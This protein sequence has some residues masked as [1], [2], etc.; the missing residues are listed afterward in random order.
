M[1]PGVV[2]LS[3]AGVISS[4]RVFARVVIVRAL[5]FVLR[6]MYYFCNIAK[7][8]LPTVQARQRKSFCFFSIFVLL[9]VLR[10]FL[11][12]SSIG[13]AIGPRALLGV[14]YRSVGYILF[15][16]IRLHAARLPCSVAASVHFVSDSRPTQVVFRFFS[17]VNHLRTF[18]CVS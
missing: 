14:M 9:F 4:I 5:C 2:S 15:T 6:K 1:L 7:P 13:F 3:N 16:W 10:I 17:V 8:T 12:I 18:V 11:I